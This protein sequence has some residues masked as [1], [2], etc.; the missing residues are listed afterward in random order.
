MQEKTSKL[1]NSLVFRNKELAEFCGISV[2]MIEQIRAGN[3]K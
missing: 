3:K 2:S 1:I